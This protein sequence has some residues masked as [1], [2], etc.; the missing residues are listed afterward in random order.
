MSWLS[1]KL[2]DPF[3]HHCEEASLKQWRDELVGRA[4]G[5]VVEVGAGTG[6]NLECYGPRVD[7]VLLT[8]PDPHMRSR[9]EGRLEQT[10]GADRFSVDPRPVEDLEEPAGSFDTVVVTL[11]LCSVDDPLEALEKMYELLTDGGRLIFIEHVGA[12]SKGRRRVQNLIEPV[13]KVCADNCHLTRRTGSV[14]REAGFEIE[15]FERDEM[16]ALLPFLRPTVRGV[17]RS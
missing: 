2:Y 17:A 13:W 9:L 3:M 16:E 1:A 14:I 4:T 7:E 11:V 15:M 5:R 10:E 12:E 6:A 8:E